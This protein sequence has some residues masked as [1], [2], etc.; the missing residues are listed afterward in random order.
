MIYS[1]SLSISRS[2]RRLFCIK[3][4]TSTILIKANDAML[5]ISFLSQIQSW[6]LTA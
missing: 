2:M 5:K 4:V 6:H 3:L 1:F